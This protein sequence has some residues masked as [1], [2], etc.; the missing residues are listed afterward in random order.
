MQPLSPLDAISPAIKRANNLLFLKPRRIGRTW[1]LCASQYLGLLGG[2]FFPVPLLLL[3]L[4]F[5]PFPNEKALL[6]FI[7]LIAAIYTVIL[8]LFFYVGVR[9]QFVN[10]EMVVTRERF[11]AP[12]WRRYG[13]RVWPV[14]G[15]KVLVSSALFLLLL[16]LFA[17]FGKSLIA[18]FTAM[19]DGPGRQSLDPQQFTAFFTAI[20]GFYAF[21]L[22][23]FLLLKLANTLIE[24]FV[25]PFYVLEPIPLREALRRGAAILRGEPLDCIVYLVMKFLLTLVG[26]MA[27][28]LANLVLLIPGMLVAG[29]VLVLGYLVI[30]HHGQ[31]SV[32][33]DV[34]GAVVVYICFIIYYLFCILGTLGYVF[35]VLEAYGIYFLAGRYAALGNL[36]EP[37]PP[38]YIYAPP[39][40]FPS[41][42]ERDRNDDDGPSLPM[43][44]AIA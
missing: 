13:S 28:Y 18:I 43:N 9:F 4:P 24:D 40:S 31:A 17:R 14:I 44:P 33:L 16:P 8:F 32:L 6:G 34:T 36:I 21:F 39:P 2:L 7:F 20:F 5:F 19:P 29:V 10:F 26:I 22:G 38:P 15:L 37:P 3:L 35:T 12:M 27:Q 1:K 42:E 11:I 41:A 25:I 23:A 30:G